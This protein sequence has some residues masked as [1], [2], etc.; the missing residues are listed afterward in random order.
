VGIS[1]QKIEESEINLME[2]GLANNILMIQSGLRSKVKESIPAQHEVS[3][4]S[5]KEILNYQVILL[6]SK[7]DYF[8]SLF[9]GL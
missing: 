1:Q 2:R 3:L 8:K 9:S 5:A 6:K 4:E 7:V